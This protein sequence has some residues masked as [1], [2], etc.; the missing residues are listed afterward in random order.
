M[1]SRRFQLLAKVSVGL[2]RVSPGAVAVLA[3][4]FSF[5]L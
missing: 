2:S 5:P 3:L 4:C 1:L